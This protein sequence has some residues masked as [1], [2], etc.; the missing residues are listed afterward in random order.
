MNKQDLVDLLEPYGQEH[1]VK[2]WEELNQTEKEHLIDDIK[3][4]DFAQMV[5]NFNRV[6]ADLDAAVQE[7]DE[8][9]Q[10]VPQELK[11]SYE[12]S[13]QEQLTS[14]ELAGL[15]A[16][17]NN[18]VAALLLAGGQGTRL[19]VNY[20]K[21]M[22]SVGLH[23]DKTLYQLQ[24]ERLV[25]LKQYANRKFPDVDEK[26]RGTSIPWYIMTSEHT[27]ESTIEFFKKNDFFGLDSNNVKFFEQYMLPCLTNDGK[28]I[29]DQKSKIS[30]APDGNG[31]LYRAL[32][33]RSILADMQQRGI[34]YV[35]VY[36]VDNILVRM[37]DPVFIGF[38]ISKNANC[39]AK[40]VK[41][42]E[43]DEKVGVICK[44]KDRFQVVE[45]SEISEKTR[46]LK[47]ADGDLLYNAGN[48][49]N[50]F[51]NTEFLHELCSKHEAELKHHVAHKKIAYINDNGERISPKDNNGIKLEKFVFDVFPFSTNFAIWEVLREEEFSPLKNGDDCKKETPTTCRN[52]LYAQHVRWLKQAGA[53]VDS[54]DAQIEVSPLVSVYGE[55]LT[56][57][58]HGKKLKCPLSIELDRSDNKVKFNGADSL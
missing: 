36:C 21:G 51:F 54:N 47:D 7:F 6:K 45:Y 37:A 4:I 3:E 58:V 5:K 20:P 48:I 35:H 12:K 22:Y 17:A 55:E 34:K 23:S 56:E 14:F 39:A 11:G 44:V 15:E 33:K 52:D 27:Q 29:L 2:Y 49:C 46:N 38:C 41:K 40:V 43:P 16:I 31:G 30:K 8:H 9:M 57:L 24:A 19:G 32:D 13:S 10:P 53:K 1:L 28:V 25:K 26:Q 42:V 50:H 18:Q